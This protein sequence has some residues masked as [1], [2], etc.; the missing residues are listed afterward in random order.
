MPLPFAEYGA[1]NTENGR[2]LCQN[3]DPEICHPLNAL[4]SAPRSL[5]GSWYTYVAVMLWRT[6]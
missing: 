5:T 2:P 1:L 3:T 6:S 4:P